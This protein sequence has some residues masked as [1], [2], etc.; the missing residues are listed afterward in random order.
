MYTC[1]IIKLCVNRLSRNI[2]SNH[3]ECVCVCVIIEVCV[4]YVCVIIEFCVC[5]CDYGGVCHV[6]CM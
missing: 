4:V 6:V 2:P 5:V 1:V 3:M